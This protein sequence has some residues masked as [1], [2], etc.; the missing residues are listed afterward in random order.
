MADAGGKKEHGLQRFFYSFVQ[1]LCWATRRN[2]MGGGRCDWAP[3][4]ART[5]LQAWCVVLS[6]ASPSTPS[7][8]WATA[9]T[10]Q[11]WRP[12]LMGRVRVVC[13]QCVCRGC[14]TPEMSLVTAYNTPH[15][16]CYSFDT[17]LMLTVTIWYSS[18]T[19]CYTLAKHWHNIDHIIVYW[20]QCV[21]MFFGRSHYV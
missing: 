11:W 21:N 14:D 7:T 13:V 17:S 9:P 18:D 12:R 2:T 5:S 20:V 3:P 19:A 6:T 15:T 10:A 1:A 8:A 4:T 16:T